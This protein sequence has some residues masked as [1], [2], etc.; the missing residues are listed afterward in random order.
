MAVEYE[1]EAGLRTSGKRVFNKICWHAL[2]QAVI[3]NMAG[4]EKIY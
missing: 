2:F 3:I 1:E 4:V